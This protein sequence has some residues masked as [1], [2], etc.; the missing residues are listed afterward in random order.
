MRLFAVRGQA[1]RGESPGGVCGLTHG[2]RELGRTPPDLALAELAGRQWGVVSVG[3]LSAVGIGRA[4]VTRRV[5]GGRLRRVHRGVYAVGGAV[6]PREG[7]CLAA[8]LACGPRAVLS[9]VSAAVHWNLLSYEPP[10]PEV[11][12]PASRKAVPG[13][14]LHRSHSLD[15]QDTTNHQGIPTTTVYRTLLDIAAHV[16]KHHL[17]RALAQ[18]ERLQPYD[19]TAITETIARANGHRGTRRL[20]TAIQEDPQFT[21]GELEARMRKLARDHGLP[22]PA[23]NYTLDVPDHQGLE[24]D[25]CFPTHRVVIEMDGWETHRIRHAFE[26][27][28]AKDAALTAAGYAV[29]CF[30]YRQLRDDPDSVADRIRAVL[31]LRYRPASAS[32][33]S[34]SSPSSIE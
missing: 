27:D 16:P 12:A 30:T 28:R 3:Q 22:Q 1:P 10:R 14:R 9:H 6:L 8:V 7:R 25:C 26:S 23:F 21:R 18:A 17:E 31:A 5:Q 4:G 2:M 15:A 32:R 19:H 33:N 20:A 34:A 13:I 29:V 11:T 24:A